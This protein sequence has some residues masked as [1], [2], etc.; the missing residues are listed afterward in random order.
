M[1]E[2]SKGV[3]QQIKDVRRRSEEEE[4]I[5]EELISAKT[6]EDSERENFRNINDGEEKLEENEIL[7]SNDANESLI[8]SS[9][10]NISSNNS[11]VENNKSHADDKK[12][13]AVNFMFTNARSLPPKIDSLVKMFDN[14]ELDFSIVTE[15]W[16]KDGKRFEKNA[17]KFEEKEDLRII[18]RNRGTRGGGVAIIFNK[19]KMSLSQIKIRNNS[20]ELVGA[21]GRTVK[22][23]RKL[24]IYAVYYPPQM[25]KKQVD[26]LN[27]C[28]SASIDQQKTAENSPRFVVCGDMNQKDISQILVDHPEIVVLKTPPTRKR[29]T[30][31][32]CLT[33]FEGEITTRAFLPLESDAGQKSDHNCIVVRALTDRV[34]VFEKK[35]HFFR[36]YTREGERR[37]GAE[38]SMIDW[39]EI[40][41]LDV[42][43][44]VKMMNDTLGEIYERNFPVK[45]IVVKST[46]PPWVN[47]AVRKASERKRKY[48]RRKGKTP[49]WKKHE[50]R[51]EDVVYEAKK[52]F[53]GKVKK[54][55]VETK[56]SA[57][58]FKAMNKLKTKEPTK[59]WNVRDLFPNLTDKETADKCVDFFSA[60]SREYK[61]IEK[62]TPNGEC[63]WKLELH[64]VSSRLKY[65]K[66]PKM[67]VKGD[68]RPELVTKFHDLLA[69][70]L[71]HIYNEII[72]SCEWPEE[73]KTETVK[74]IPKSKIPQSLKEVR[75]ISCT[76]LFS[77][78]F[79]YF[80]LKKL[81]QGM[82]LS[83]NQFGGIKGVSIDH[84]LMETWHEILM[85]L[86]DRSAAS[87]LVSIDFSKAFNR[88]DH[89]ACIQALQNAGIGEEVVG[90]VKAFLYDRKMAVH[91]NGTVSEMRSAPGGAPQGSVLGSYLFCA[92]TDSL[93]VR[94]EE[95]NQTF[96]ENGQEMSISSGERSGSGAELSPI[97][98]PNHANWNLQDVSITSND[99]DDVI[100]FGIRGPNRRL[101]DTT[102]ESELASQTALEEFLE[103]EEE[104]TRSKPTV[105]AYIDDY[106]VIE[107]VRTS[108][109]IAHITTGKTTYQIH[110]PESEGVLSQV[111]DKSKSI[112][113]VVNNEKT[114][115]LC[116]HP[117]GDEMRTFMKADGS[118][119]KSQ[120]RL[121]ILGFTFGSTPDVSLNTETTAVKFARLLWGL[122]FLRKSGMD[123][124]DL[125]M[126]YK[127]TIR[128]VLDFA[129]V[130]Y[131]SLLTQ[132]QSQ[133]IEQ[134]QLRAMKVV[135][136]ETVSYKSVIQ[137][138][139]IELMHDR[140]E[141]LR[142]KFALKTRKNP[143]F[144]HWFP[145]NR[146]ITHDLRRREK[147]YIPKL[148]TERA[149]KSPII[150]L[151]RILNEMDV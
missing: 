112:G 114:Q 33:N 57:G 62:P 43:A 89:S 94:T 143:R 61:P 85:N 96:D 80:L 37:F 19:N 26:E 105:K 53:L 92:T 74:I 3:R 22:D 129:A 128:P 132:G 110:A 75:N 122:R 99:S 123:E 69:I 11:D 87:S 147:Y 45:Q 13:N 70:P 71:L 34:H 10:S 63:D 5:E 4:S 8:N 131:H 113:M 47:N 16:M 118:T 95:R 50:K 1:R 101:M 149:I 48:Y 109:A 12:V 124:H 52:A 86:E 14:F 83:K 82:T 76:P 108:T 42:N 140:R 103:L 39:A 104:W 106:N 30:I 29:E 130:S 7:R 111:K 24:V 56:N 142:K 65:C 100:D 35:K 145:L 58:F 9:I 46:D 81:R 125:L 84:F 107:K 77:K 138:G 66:K 40:H 49:T 137:S 23:A 44:A 134:L 2:D 139:N 20:F 27:E 18:E 121:K 79:E 97:A 88:M 31:D 60:I 119:I 21:S 144:D 59:P 148:K 54:E 117:R 72:R 126:T 17:R 25:K 150:Q 146:G 116:I 55:F 41:S 90:V 98:P 141:E 136:G 38:L 64:E 91:V 51:A 6:G 151:R 102:I 115:M 36:P 15:T 73:W 68:I 67:T 133:A 28:L 93:A 120:D 78:V 135:F 32:L 127:A